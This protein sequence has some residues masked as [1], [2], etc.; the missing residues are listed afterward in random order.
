[1][2]ENEHNIFQSPSELTYQ[3]LRM[4]NQRSLPLHQCGRKPIKSFIKS[5]TGCSTTC[6]NIPLTIRWAKSM[7]TKF[8]GHLSS[9]HSVRKILLVSE[10]TVGRQGVRQH[11]RSSWAITRTTNTRWFAIRTTSFMVICCL[12]FHTHVFSQ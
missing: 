7:Q 4:R 11:L 6:L 10:N 8:I 3:S 1:M 12:I 9:T 5:I 2:L